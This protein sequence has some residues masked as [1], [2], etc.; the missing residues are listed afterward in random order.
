MMIEGIYYSECDNGT[1]LIPAIIKEIG[2]DDDN[3]VIG[4]SLMGDDRLDYIT[5]AWHGPQ[6]LTTGRMIAWS[7][8]R[9]RLIAEFRSLPY[10]IH[11]PDSELEMCQIWN[12]L[13]PCSETERT[14]A[15]TN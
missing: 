3:I 8:A 11:A 14:Y 13:W 15:A 9:D 5:V 4:P 1:N 7:A 10:H 6:G 2:I 12:S